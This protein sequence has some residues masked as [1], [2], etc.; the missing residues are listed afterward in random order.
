MLAVYDGRN[1]VGRLLRRVQAGVED[2]TADDISLGVYETEAAAASALWRHD[3]AQM[4][5]IG[6]NLTSAHRPRLVA[7]VTEAISIE[8]RLIAADDKGDK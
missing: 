2:F 6:E 8:T 3:S 5:G 1:C 4:D 7:S